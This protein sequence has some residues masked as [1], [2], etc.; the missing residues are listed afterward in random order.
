MNIKNFKISSLL[1]LGLGFVFAFLFPLEAFAYDFAGETG[2]EETG[3]ETGHLAL[4][5]I[6]LDNIII[7]IIQFILSLLGVIFLFQMIFGG[8]IWMTSSGNEDKVSQ[9]KKKIIN[10]IIG[11]IV[12]LA[13]YAV[14]WFVMYSFAW[15]SLTL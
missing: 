8:Y 4:G 10:S 1:C 6:N 7:G 5:L 3:G 2:L 14:T 11:L 13:A 15:K 12:V 9:A